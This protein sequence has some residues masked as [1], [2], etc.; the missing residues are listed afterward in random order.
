VVVEQ[1]FAVQR[2]LPKSVKTLQRDAATYATPA[3]QA[4]KL[5]CRAGFPEGNQNSNAL[6]ATFAVVASGGQG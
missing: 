3:T 4:L 6:A 1:Q 5:R 2:V